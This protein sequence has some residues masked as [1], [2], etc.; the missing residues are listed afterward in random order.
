MKDCPRLGWFSDERDHDW[1][2]WEIVETIITMPLAQKPR[3]ATCQR[4]TCLKCGFI[5]VRSL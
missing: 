4:R 2:K 1:S 3:E 5:E